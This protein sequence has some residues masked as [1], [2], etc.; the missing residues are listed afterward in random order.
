MAPGDTRY[1]LID[2]IASMISPAPDLAHQ[3]VTGEIFRQAANKLAGKTCPAF[4]APVDVRLP[5]RDE[6]DDQIDTV[7]HRGYGGIR[8]Q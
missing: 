6:A 5:K 1:E 8:R 7:V 4:I 3:D 2:G